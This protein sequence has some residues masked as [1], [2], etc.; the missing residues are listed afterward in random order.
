MTNFIPLFPLDIVV[1][2]G[3]KLNLHIFEPKYK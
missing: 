2:P 3:E 1:Y